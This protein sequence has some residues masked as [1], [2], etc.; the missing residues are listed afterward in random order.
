MSAKVRLWTGYVFTAIPVLMLTFSGVMKLVRP[1]AVVTEFTRLGYP[2]NVIVPLGVVELACAAL[3]LF[4]RTA[5]LGAILVAGYLGGATATHVRVGDPTFFI[6]PLLG[7]MA[8]GGI[9]LRD[10]RLRALLP[11]RK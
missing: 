11:L 7:A 3:Y 2:E 4:P 9:F 8:F 10:E 1:E 5:V 6:P